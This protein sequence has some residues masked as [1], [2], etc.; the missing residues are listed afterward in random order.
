MPVYRLDAPR[1]AVDHPL[2]KAVISQKWCFA[3][4]TVGSILLVSL[5]GIGIHRH[6]SDPTR[7]AERFLDCC[8]TQ[9]Y[10]DLYFLFDDSYQQVFPRQASERLLPALHTKIPRAYRIQMSNYPKTVDGL[11]VDWRRFHVRAEFEEPEE[12]RRAHRSFV[13]I[14]IQQKEGNWRVAFGPTYR[15]LFLGLYDGA[16]EEFLLR[17]VG[18]QAAGRSIA[19][20]GL[21]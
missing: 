11:V 21:K 9:N 1:R 10:R 2:H 18:Q 12:A 19:A 13:V 6:L 16:G 8:C 7:I 5:L 3:G 17:T 4:I 14:L 20:L 15:N